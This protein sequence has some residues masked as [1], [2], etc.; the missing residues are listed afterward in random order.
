MYMFVSSC[1]EE[2]WRGGDPSRECFAEVFE[3]RF[4]RK[5]AFAADGVTWRAEAHV[6]IHVYVRVTKEFV[7][8]VSALQRYMSRGLSETGRTQETWCFCLQKRIEASM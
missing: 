8:T 6:G 4:Y 2:L 5:R 1:F 7:Q 3:Q